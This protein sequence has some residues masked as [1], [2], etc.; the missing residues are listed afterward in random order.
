M[1]R[2][3]FDAEEIAKEFAGTG[4]GFLGGRQT[5]GDQIRSRKIDIRFSR[6]RLASIK[7]RLALI[8]EAQSVERIVENQAEAIWDKIEIILARFH[9]V[10]RQLLQRHDNRP[11][12]DINDEYDMQ[13][14]LHA[15]LWLFF[16]DI[17]AEEWTPSYAGGASRADF[18]LKAEK[19]FI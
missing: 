7:E 5:L 8:P 14:L 19:T 18:L 13:D 12:L 17:R 10:V 1:L 11:T 6:Q 15:L 16:D 9:Q 2:R 3:I 4:G